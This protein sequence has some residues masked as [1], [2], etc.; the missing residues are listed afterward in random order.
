MER[1]WAWEQKSL[2]SDT[3]LMISALKPLGP[4]FFT[5]SNFWS[6]LAAAKEKYQDYW[7]SGIR[8]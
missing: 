2:F 1:T 5:F 3:K 6:L 4:A 8:E 7:K